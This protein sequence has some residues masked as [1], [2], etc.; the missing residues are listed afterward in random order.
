LLGRSLS[1]LQGNKACQGTLRPSLI[2]KEK[3]KVEEGKFQFSFNIDQTTKNL[4]V[5]GLSLNRKE[6]VG[7]HRR[8]GLNWEL[9]EDGKIRKH[10]GTERSRKTRGRV[11]PIDS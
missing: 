10:L 3:S 7:D 5:T 8:K 11:F 6:K 9:S 4:L 1:I 2:Q